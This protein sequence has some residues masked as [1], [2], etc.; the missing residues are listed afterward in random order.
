MKYLPETAHLSKTL[1]QVPESTIFTPHISRD[2]KLWRNTSA[3][4]VPRRPS[5]AGIH[6]AGGTSHPPRAY[7]TERHEK[8]LK[9]GLD[10]PAHGVSGTAAALLNIAR[11]ACAPPAIAPHLVGGGAA[12]AQWIQL[13]VVTECTVDQLWRSEIRHA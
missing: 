8:C 6:L 9:L 4:N 11:A 7:L 5:T 3:Q 12:H 1:S 13:H 2:T 10:W